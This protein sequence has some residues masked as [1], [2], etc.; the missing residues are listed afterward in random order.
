VALDDLTDQHWEVARLA[1]HGAFQPDIDGS[2]QK[3]DEPKEILK[4][5]DYHLD[6]Q[7]KGEDHHFSIELASSAIFAESSGHPYGLPAPL[8]ERI[9]RF[10]C[11]RP[12]F[13]RGVRSVLPPNNPFRLR[14]KI[15]GLITLMS[16]QWF[17]SPTSIMEPEEMP[18]FCEHLAVF[19]IDEALRHPFIQWRGV[20]ILFEMLRSPEWRKHIAPRF[21]S[22]FA[23]S[24]RVDGARESV[25]WCLQ[26]AIEL[27]EF[28]RGLPH[29]EGL[30]WW[31]GALWLYHSKLDATVRDEVEKVARDVSLGDG[32]SDLNLGLYL[33]IIGQD[34]T[35]IQQ[36]V[37]ELRSEYE[38]DGLAELEDQLIA[39]EENRRRLSR[40]TGGQQ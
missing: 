1:A 27:L 25:R 6:L 12:S 17:N 11:A 22:M 38:T 36:E 16:N 15:I 21:W 20:T 32:I 31:Y 4:F 33:N 8:L 39:L 18:E 7:G 37:D 34:V 2:V 24:T 28:M 3:E 40:I 23:Y 26:N 30:K 5:L 9:G 13:V 19:L 10:D 14:D 29:G 35:R